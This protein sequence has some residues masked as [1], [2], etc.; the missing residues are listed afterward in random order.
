ML[1]VH[2]HPSMMTISGLAS[3]TVLRT[4]SA[5]EATRTSWHPPS[6]SMPARPSA[7]AFREPTTTDSHPLISIIGAG[8]LRIASVASRA[9]GWTTYSGEHELSAHLGTARSYGAPD[10]DSSQLG[11]NQSQ[12]TWSTGGRI[13]TL[14]RSIA[15][16]PRSKALSYADVR[17]V[18]AWRCMAGV[19]RS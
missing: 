13:N 8:L 12:E 9:T 16:R 15:D 4:D 3:S 11:H 2:M 6:V 10:A 14:P 5:V 18:N 17:Y 1:L 7:S 19:P